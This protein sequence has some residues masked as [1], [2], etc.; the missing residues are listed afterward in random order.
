MRS[1]Y[2]CALYLAVV[3]PGFAQTPARAGPGLPND[4]REIF[5]AAAP[6]YDFTSPELKPWH[7]KATYQL[8]DE[9]GKHGEQGTY[10]YWW[11]SPK[12]YRST[13][14]RPGAT[15]T[16]WHTSD[17]KHAYQDTGDRLKFFEYKLQDALLSP[18]PRSAD[19]DPEKSRLDQEYLGPKN[20]K[21]PCIM[22]IPLMPNYKDLKTVPLGL[23][24]TYC[25]DPHL[26][27]LRASRDFGTMTTQF[28]NIVKVQNRYLA[29]EILVYEEKRKIL[30]AEVEPIT[31]LDPSD[32]ALTLPAR[33]LPPSTP[34]S[35]VD[36]TTSK[37]LTVVHIGAGLMTTGMLVKK[38]QPI[39]P[40]QA[41]D[42]HITGTVVLQARIGRDGGI[43][44]LRVISAPDPLLA[45]AALW[46]VSQWEYKPYLLN[47]DPVEVM[48]T[49]NVI[50]TLRR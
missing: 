2:F 31:T 40:K 28:N 41:K 26:P 29:R 15:H 48:T 10:E 39:Y 44:D 43:H 47:G 17:G 7:L 23:F 1:F 50:Y 8:Y 30:S 21:F 18:L 42:A 16:E 32:P 46:A 36:G 19:L 14:T 9:K 27:V 35:S 25:F 3:L 5:A 13:W 34:T 38:T 20:G 49:V 37:Q 45:I 11:A 4:P 12:V 33:S 24:P 22:V 6:F